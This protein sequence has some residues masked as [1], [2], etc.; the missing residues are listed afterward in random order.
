MAID[1]TYKIE[2]LTPMGKHEVTIILKRAGS[3][4][5]GIADGTLGHSEFTG[6]IKGNNVAWIDLVNTPMGEIKMEF[7]GKINGDDISGEVK[8]GNFGTYPFKGKRV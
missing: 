6:T 1:G 5:T 3:N 2:I 7:T 8:A 4:L